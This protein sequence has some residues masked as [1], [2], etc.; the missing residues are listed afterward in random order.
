MTQVMRRL[1]GYSAPN[2]GYLRIECRVVYL[3]VDEH[4]EVVADHEGLHIGAFVLLI[5]CVCQR[6]V[7]FKTPLV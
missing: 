6:P 4:G 2:R 7:P 1:A 3:A 5:D